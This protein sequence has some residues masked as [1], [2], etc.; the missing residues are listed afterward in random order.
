MLILQEPRPIIETI[1]FI[2]Q[3]KKLLDSVMLDKLNLDG[4]VEVDEEEATKE[5][6]KGYKT[7]REKDDPGVFVLPI[8]LESKI[9]SFALADTGSNINVLP[10]QL[11][12]KLGREEAKPVGKKITMLDYSKAEPMG[13]LRDVRFY[14]AAVK[15]KQE[16]KDSEE[17]EEYF[18]KRDKNEHIFSKRFETIQ[19]DMHLEKMV[20]FLGSLPV[21]LQHMEWIPSY[22]DSFSKKGG[23]DGM[24]HT[25]IIVGTSNRAAKTRYNTNL[26]CLLPK[27]I[28][29]PV[30]V[31]WGVLNNMGYA[32]EIEAML[33]IKFRLCGQGHTLTL[34][35]FAR[36]LSLYH[37]AEINEKGFEVYFRGGLRS[38]E[39]F[40]ARDYWL[41]ISSEEELHLSRS[42]VSTIRTKHQNGYVN[43]VW[44]MAKWLKRK[45]VR[46]Q[47][48]SMIYCG[49]LI[50]KLAKRMGL[51]T[52]E[53]L[54][55][56]SAS[57]YCKALDTTTLRELISPNGK[58][59]T[60]DPTPR[61]PRV[62]MPK[63]QRPSMH[64]LYDRI[65]R[66]EIRQGELKRISR[67]QSYHSDRYAGVYEHM[68]GHYGY[69]LQGAYAPPS[70]VKEQPHEDED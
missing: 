32:K 12:T 27:Q 18:V 43:V 10:Y 50:T 52:D 24:W 29:S 44:L 14:V 33:E 60:E 67:R 49:Q 39:N 28:Y 70:Y 19:E 62:A 34:L 7:L 65:G 4:E 40:N 25:K 41:S 37:A 9:D 3:H 61:V 21:P 31:D 36:R 58:L 56:L 59:I 48:E 15:N 47:R 64:D 5:V 6:I 46:S 20:A 17:E 16:E 68:A 45:G 63:G 1:K 42:L 69:T 66:M 53:V 38:D 55:S 8:R 22:S 13:I 11:Y 35:E 51:L 23:G 57:T 54:N 2:D 26:A 30:I